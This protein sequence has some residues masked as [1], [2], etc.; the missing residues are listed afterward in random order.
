MDPDQT[1]QSYAVLTNYKPRLLHCL[2][3]LQKHISAYRLAVIENNY[4][5]EVAA[6]LFISKQ[7][8]TN[9]EYEQRSCSWSISHLKEIDKCADWM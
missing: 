8:L 4:E 5:L 1:V 9:Y 2:S 6:I 3:H 7:K